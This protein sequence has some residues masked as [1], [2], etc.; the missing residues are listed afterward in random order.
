MMIVWECIVLGTIGGVRASP[1][2][3]MW[4]AWA[5]MWEWGAKGC[6]KPMVGGTGRGSASHYVACLSDQ[7]RGVHHINIP[8]EIASSYLCRV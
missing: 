2:T 8:M 7:G 3:P 4:A 1:Y 6:Y 5:V